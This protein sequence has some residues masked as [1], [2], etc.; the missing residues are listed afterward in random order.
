MLMPSA[1]RT[2]D[3]RVSYGCHKKQQ[4]SFFKQN[5]QCS[6]FRIMFVPPRLSYQSDDMSPEENVFMPI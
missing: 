3:L 4:L 5:D 1:V 6:R 2:L